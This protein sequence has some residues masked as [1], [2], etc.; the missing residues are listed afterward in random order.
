MVRDY[1]SAGNY[2]LDLFVRDRDAR[3]DLNEAQLQQIRGQLSASLE[4]SLHAAMETL[5]GVS[6]ERREFME[7][8]NAQQG[9]EQGE[10]MDTAEED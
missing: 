2:A 9:E 3:F 10:G 5:N 1:R 8:F 6:D 4:S 7:Q